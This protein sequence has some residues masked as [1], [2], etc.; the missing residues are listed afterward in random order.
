[1]GET[2]FGGR[3][4]ILSLKHAEFETAVQYPSEDV[5]ETVGMY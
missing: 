4:Q 3:G 5:K 2:E 1:M